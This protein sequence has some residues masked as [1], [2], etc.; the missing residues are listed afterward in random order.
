MSCTSHRRRPVCRCLRGTCR[1]PA[2]APILASERAVGPTQPSEAGRPFRVCQEGRCGTAQPS[3][4]PGRRRLP[5]RLVNETS[6][7]LAVPPMP[8]SSSLR[9]RVWG[10]PD[11][12]SAAHHPEPVQDPGTRHLQSDGQST[13][14]RGSGPPGTSKCLRWKSRICRSVARGIAAGSA[15]T[16]QAESAAVAASG[17][18][19][20]ASAQDTQWDRRRQ[21]AQGVANPPAAVRLP[22]PCR[23]SARPRWNGAGH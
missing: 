17:R 15:A 13:A 23:R 7:Y 9:F 20:R 18:S 12:A 11:A 8:A 21:P 10:A 2:D 3:R 22:A 5:G 4:A 16:L 1:R 6:R 19:I 14:A